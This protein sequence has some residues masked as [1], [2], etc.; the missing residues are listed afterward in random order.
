M[1]MV[2]ENSPL[3]SGG[4]DVDQLRRREEGTRVGGATM[5]NFGRGDETGTT[6]SVC[7]VS[8][9]QSGPSI[10]PPATPH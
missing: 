5:E 4:K 10:I 6:F 1:V 2:T 8:E 9:R 3:L 7:V